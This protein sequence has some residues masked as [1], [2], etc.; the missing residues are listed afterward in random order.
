MLMRLPQP[1]YLPRETARLLT[2]S[3]LRALGVSRGRSY[4]SD[5]SRPIRG[6]IAAPGLD[7]AAPDVLLAAVQAILDEGHFLSR[8]TAARELEIP[9]RASGLIE[10]GAVCP[11][12]P[13]HR[14]ELS[15]HQLRAGVLRELPQ[16]PLW[17]PHPA[18]V[19]GLLAAFGDTGELV[20]AGDFLISGKSRHSA[21]VCSRGELEETVQRFQGMRGIGQLKRAL[22]LLCTGV[23]S[24]AESD[25]RLVIVRAGLPTPQTS[26]PVETRDRL[27]HADL[28]YPDLRIAI[29]CDGAYHFDGSVHNARLDNE[30]IE[31]M[32]DAGWRVLRA[33]GLDLRDPR[34]FLRRLVEAIQQRGLDVSSAEAIARG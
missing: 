28:G 22:L 11:R 31:A 16:G 14:A 19:W 34:N 21:P 1:L 29:E 24:P 27:L 23:E 12:K 20:A 8:R 18:D 30:R 5:L 3:E 32:I 25:L 6:V 33:T 2:S 13:R 7:P 9:V 15:G 26:C 17:L 4:S 10:V